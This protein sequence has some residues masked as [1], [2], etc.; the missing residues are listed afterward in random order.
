MAHVMMPLG[1]SA[2][3]AVPNYPGRTPPQSVPYGGRRETSGRRLAPM[4]RPKLTK[5]MKKA[6]KW[7]RKH[8]EPDSRRSSA[9]ILV[10]RSIFPDTVTTVV[11]L[12]TTLNRYVGSPA[13]QG[14]IDQ[15]GAAIRLY[16]ASAANYDWDRHRRGSWETATYPTYTPTTW[17]TGTANVATWGVT[18]NA[19]ITLTATNATTATFTV[20]M[21]WTDWN[22]EWV[23]P[24]ASG[25]VDRC[26]DTEW[27][28]WQGRGHSNDLWY[29]PN[30]L[31]GRE[32]LRR[33]RLILQDAEHQQQRMERE[34]AA[35]EAQRRW[36][37]EAPA[38]AAAAAATEERRKTALTR[39]YSL[40]FQHLTDAQKNMFESEN[41]FL[42]VGQ[43]GHLYEIR[44]GIMH[45]IFRL[46]DQGRAIEEL[47]CYIPNV[48]E[49]D[50]LLGQMLHLMANE[51]DFR[52][53]SNRW[54]LRDMN[55]TDRRLPLAGRERPAEV[56]RIALPRA[57]APLP[58]LSQPVQLV[59]PA[60]QPRAA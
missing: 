32:R 33:E 52:R 17:G 47:C 25:W 10:P 24:P 7:A 54:E 2:R 3:H 56:G 22:A 21:S 39:S 23:T 20:P 41:R 29:D 28:H 49:G 60:A 58:Q 26:R 57:V 37:A 55:Q 9:R 6:L 34:A 43:S 30:D 44:R 59:Q 53:G 12:E 16:T 51:D 5:A 15:M 48:P 18:N 38:R 46:D 42:I 31:V 14:T 36:E 27:R 11:N 35:V 50:V 13:T 8:P 4:A 40:L 19:T 45:N 1:A